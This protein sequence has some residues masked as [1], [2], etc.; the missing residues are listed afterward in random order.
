VHAGLTRI[1]IARPLYVVYDLS[2]PD[3]LVRVLLVG[4]TDQ[5]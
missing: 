3:L 5:I 2:P 1:L 4:R